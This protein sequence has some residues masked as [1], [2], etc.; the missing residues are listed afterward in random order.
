M[1]FPIL[2]QVA[3][4]FLLGCFLDVKGRKHTSLPIIKET[5]SNQR[6]LLYTVSHANS[7]Q[8]FLIV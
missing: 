7:N 8:L 4:L 1:Y 6:S 3:A 2:T 5:E